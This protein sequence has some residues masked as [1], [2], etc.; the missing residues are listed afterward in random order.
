MRTTSTRSGSGRSWPRATSSSRCARRRW[1]RRRAPSSARCRS[2][3]RSSSRTSAGSRSCRTTSASRWRRTSARSRRSRRRSSG[4]PPTTR[5]AQAMG[6]AAARLARAEH[7]LDARGRALRGRAR[8]GGG[9]R[10]PSGRRWSREVAEAAAEIGI[11]ADDP[12]AGRARGAAATRSGLAVRRRPSAHEHPARS[13]AQSRSGPGSPA[14]SPSRRSSAT[15]S[16]AAR[17]APWIM[18]D[19]LIYS[20]L[21]KSFADSGPLPRPRRGDGRL[22]HRLPGADRARVGAVRVPCRRRT[23][24]RRRS[25]RSSCRSRPCPRT[26]SPG[27]CSPVRLCARRRG[28]RPWPIPSMVYTATLMTENAFYPIFLTA[29]AGARAVARAA[30]A[31]RGRR[32]SLG[33]CLVAYLTRQQAVALLPALLTAPLPRRRAGRRSAA[34]RCMYGLAAARRGRRR[35]SSRS[36]ADA[37]PLG[38]FGAYEVAGTAHYSVGEVAKWFLYH[39]AELDLSLGVLPVRGADPARARAGARLADRDRI[40]VA[41]AVSAV[42]L[43]RARGGDLRLRADVPDR[44]AEHV[45]RRAA[46]PHRAPRLDRARRCRGRSLRRRWRGCLAAGLPLRRCRTSDFIGLNAVSD[47]LALLPLGWLVERGLALERRRARRRLQAAS[48]PALRSCSCRAATRSRCRRSCSSTSPSRS[49]RS[50]PSTA[51]RRAQHLFGGITT[52][53]RDWIDRA[54]GPDGRR[55]ARLD[56]EHGQ[57]HDLGERVLQPQR[58]HDLHDRAGGARGPRPDAG[59]PSTAA[60]GYL[61]RAD[62]TLVRVAIRARPTRRSSS[63]GRRGR[64]RRDEA[65]GALPRRRAAA[66]ARVRRAASTRRTRGRA[67]TSRTRATTARGGTLAVE[68][69]SDPALFIAAERRHRAGRRPGRSARAQVDPGQSK[70]MRVPLRVGSATRASCASPSRGRRCPTVVTGGPNPDPRGSACTSTASPTD[71]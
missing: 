13:P 65:D 26:S 45:L 57:V 42:L 30:D 20:E 68:L 53:H 18:V 3:S 21:A 23:R 4:S 48:S 44:G 24:R 14:S 1:A 54:V 51:T 40:F 32:S 16:G 19:E 28:A 49:T 27:A 43:A 31:A 52:P 71:P 36:R 9:R 39:V 61:R 29:R 50:S 10:A 11:D 47:T 70:T 58:R 5:R 62:G 25:M 38:I 63:K 22:R 64:R 34:T 2:A 56:G 46:L 69:Q 41:A 8:G 66:A 35:R 67:S 15:S 55:G 60:T 17:S 59:R 12:E 37:S 33:V 7:A 6:A